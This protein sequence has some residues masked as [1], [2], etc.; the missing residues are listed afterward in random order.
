MTIANKIKRDLEIE[1]LIRQKV[2]AVQA[3]YTSLMTELMAAGRIPYQ[4]EEAA[5]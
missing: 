1:A 3:Y 4:P 5:A 2:E